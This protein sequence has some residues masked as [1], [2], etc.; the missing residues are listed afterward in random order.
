MLGRVL[1]AL[2]AFL[3]FAIA[4]TM[5]LQVFQRFVLNSSL[6]WPDELVGNLLASLAFVGG[7]LAMRDGEHIRV[8][9]L[10]NALP[11]RWVPILRAVADIASIT[12]L[13][14]VAW[15]AWPNVQRMWRVN[16]TTLP[17]LPIGLFMASVPICFVLMSYYVLRNSVLTGHKDPF[18]PDMREE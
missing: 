9:F 17:V 1:E 8:R 18:D 11:E 4:S 14:I 2:A 7:T 10:W 3:V 16:L 13:L 15:Y 12:F 6:P 5:V